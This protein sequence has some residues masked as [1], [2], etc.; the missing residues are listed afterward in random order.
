[1]K[2]EVATISG[3]GL[4]GMVFQFLHPCGTMRRETRKS[5]A[6][7]RRAAEWGLSTPRNGSR[8]THDSTHPRSREI[9][10]MEI[11]RRTGL[12]LQASAMASGDCALVPPCPIRSSP[13]HGPGRDGLNSWKWAKMARP[14]HEM[15]VF[16][17][18]GHGK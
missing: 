16:R 11:S 15:A 10:R 3:S 7:G 14:I 17:Q 13:L 4:V 6:M 8:L 12:L 5:T 9:G 1:V 2:L 18:M